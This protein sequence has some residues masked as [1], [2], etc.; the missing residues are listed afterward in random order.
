MGEEEEEVQHILQLHGFPLP[1]IPSHQGR[2]NE[3]LDDRLTEGI[4]SA[5]MHSGSVSH[6]Q[7][8]FEPES[9]PR[10][11]TRWVTETVIRNETDRGFLKT[12]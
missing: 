8:L 3:L 12:L 4:F 6:L 5:C 10:I 7:P 1:F 2:G 11:E 9:K